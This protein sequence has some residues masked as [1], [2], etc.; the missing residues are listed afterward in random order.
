[1]HRKTFVLSG[2]LLVFAL[3]PATV[4]AAPATNH[5]GTDSD[6]FVDPDFCGTGVSIDG[7][8]TVIFTDHFGPGDI[9]HSTARGQTTFTNPSTG[10][11]VVVSFAG[12]FT[13]EVV[14]GDPEGVHT[15]AFTNKGL[16]EMI[17]T[18]HGA[19]LLRDAGYITFLTTFDGDEFLNQ[20]VSV[21]N[22]PHPDADSD[23][24]LF[25]E[26]TIAALGIP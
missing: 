21:N 15:H 19:V 7:S 16:P 6:T 18:P 10:D 22:G 4:I 5:H 11:S 12:L 1:V 20:T 3:M 17:K 26:V 8:F 23:F 14:S 2:A 24:A 13:D 9:F 25:C